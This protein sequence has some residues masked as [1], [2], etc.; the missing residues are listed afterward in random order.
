M[1]LFL[2]NVSGDCM[3]AF[4]LSHKGMSFLT[5]LSPEQIF[6]IIKFSRVMT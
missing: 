3:S 4:H 5:T 6:C 1:S 2:P